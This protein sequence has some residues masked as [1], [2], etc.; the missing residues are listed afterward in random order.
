MLFER[1]TNSEICP[2]GAEI[3]Q[4]RVAD[5]AAAQPIDLPLLCRAQDPKL[6]PC[7]SC[8]CYE[9]CPEIKEVLHGAQERSSCLRYV[10]C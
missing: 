3:M 6:E 10:I 7:L 1:D 9:R 5:N 2:S 4:M 8:R